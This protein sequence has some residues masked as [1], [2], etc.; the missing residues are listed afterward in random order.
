MERK[1]INESAQNN[2]KMT[3]T[4]HEKRKPNVADVVGLSVE[5]I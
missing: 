2:E 3:K 1:Q 4:F 5:F